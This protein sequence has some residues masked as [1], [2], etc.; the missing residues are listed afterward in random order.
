MA[1]APSG[2][3][4]G[5]ADLHLHAGPALIAREFGAEEAAAAAASA[6]C[7]AILLKDH[8]CPTMSLAKALDE[9]YS[10]A[11]LRVFGGTV[12][13]NSVGGLNPAAVQAAAGFG[14]KAIWMPT[15][16]AGNH[17]ECLKRKGIVFPAVAGKGETAESFITWADDKGRPTE[18]AE[19]VL[20]ILAGNTDIILATGHGK[21]RE[22]DALVKRAA[23]M[24]I[25]R[26]LVNHPLFMVGADDEDLKTWTG[27]GA[28]LEFTAIA[29]LPDSSMYSIPPAQV[30]RVINLIGPEKI[31]LSS[32]L[33]LKGCGA[34]TEGMTRFMDSLMEEGIKDGQLAMMTRDNPAALLGL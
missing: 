10:P 16:S 32:D 34:Q 14:A 2:P 3:L 18:A 17:R 8:H 1:P 31:V 30:G 19:A 27:L 25:T 28:Y 22:T 21:A 23:K 26:I 24:G 6:G 15:V 7:R 11:G 4:Q 5:F 9:R 33:G 29:S 13:N 12:L 20:D